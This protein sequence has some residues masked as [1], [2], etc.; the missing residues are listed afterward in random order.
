[1]Y[2]YILSF[3]TRQKL[4]SFIKFIVKCEWK[5]FK[6]R[7]IKY[8]ILYYVFVITFVIPFYYGSGTVTYYSSLFDKLWFWFRFHTA[9]SYS[10]YG[11]GSTTLKPACRRGCFLLGG[12]CIK[13]QKQRCGTVTIFYGSGSNFW[14]VMVPVFIFLLSK[15][16]YKEKVYQFHQ[17]Y[18]KM[19]KKKMLNEGNQ[20][21][22]FISSSG[23]GTVISY[24]SGSGSVFLTSFGSGFTSQKVTVHTVL[25][26]VPHRWTE[27]K[28]FQEIVFLCLLGLNHT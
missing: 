24:G 17:I 23:S 12:H 7:E 8:T 19:W 3:F 6:W 1:M 26:P 4:I 11:S 27:V 18:C 20:I 10:S 5:K 16:F 25:V 28:K 22:N 21:H 15:L 14:K 9:K 2:F 13:K